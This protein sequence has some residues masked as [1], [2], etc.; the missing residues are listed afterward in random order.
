MKLDKED[1]KE[2]TEDLGEMLQDAEKYLAIGKVLVVAGKPVLVDILKTI[3]KTAVDV[4][5]ALEPEIAEYS[6]ISTK[7]THRDFENY[8]TAGFTKE[9][10]FAL[11]LA[12]IKPF[13]S[14]AFVNSVKDGAKSASTKS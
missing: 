4:R 6:A 11:V 8:R 12:S 13:N 1:V 10:S 9:Q 14:E 7:A 2:M 5:R 3:M